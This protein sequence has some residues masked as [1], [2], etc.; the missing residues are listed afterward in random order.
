MSTAGGTSLCEATMQK[1][2]RLEN[3][4]RRFVVEVSKSRQ[5]DIAEGCDTANN[6]LMNRMDD[7]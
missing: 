5:E 7:N 3:S 2:V 6:V 4:I 1:P